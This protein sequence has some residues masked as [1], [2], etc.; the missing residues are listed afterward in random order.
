MKAC[1]LCGLSDNLID[2]N[3]ANL[4]KCKR[5]KRFRAQKKFKYWDIELPNSTNDAAYHLDCF[6]KFAVL[7]RKYKEEFEETFRDDNVST[8]KNF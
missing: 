3:G 6:R 2:F 8:I 1:F 7:K 4:E 5:M